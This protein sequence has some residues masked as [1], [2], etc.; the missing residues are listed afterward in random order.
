[1]ESLICYTLSAIVALYIIYALYRKMTVVV[2]NATGSADDNEEYKDPGLS[3]NPLYLAT[4]NAS[5]ISYLKSRLGE[6]STLRTQVDAMKEQVESN[7]AAVQSINTSLQN[8]ATESMPDQKTSN[9]LAN[10]G[11]IEP[12]GSI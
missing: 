2:E 12:P 5:N 8:T 1:M 7:S 9:E 6:I 10:S 4:I 11:N 3:Q